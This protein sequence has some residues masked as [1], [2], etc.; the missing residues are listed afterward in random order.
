MCG[1]MYVKSDAEHVARRFPGVRVVEWRPASPFIV[2]S[3]PAPAVLN[4]GRRAVAWCRW[5]LIP[6]WA[7]DPKIGSRMFNARAE[8]LAEKPSF[9]Q[10]LRRRRCLVLCDGFVEWTSVPGSRRRQPMLVHM[11]SGEPFALAG[12][13]DVWRG[14]ANEEIAS[15]T[16][17]TTTPNALLATIHNRMPAILP[18][19]A[20]EEWLAPDERDPGPLVA[21]LGPYP[22]D[23][24]TMEA[25]VLPPRK[26]DDDGQQVFPL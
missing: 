24:M 2:P 6:S 21:L 4:D 23:Q 9:R 14:P 12:L 7:D 20:Q 19:I 17:I 18:D 10:S 22:P 26:K 5:G 8:T 11:K 3:Q 25:T 16:V 1:M 13:W 15:C